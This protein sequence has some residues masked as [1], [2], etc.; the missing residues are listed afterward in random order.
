MH[1]LIYLYPELQAYYC[2]IAL[3][4]F[5]KSLKIPITISNTILL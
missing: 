5:V 1:M 4:T 3:L 2:Q